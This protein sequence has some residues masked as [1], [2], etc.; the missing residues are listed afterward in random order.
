MII[1]FFLYFC[2]VFLSTFTLNLTLRVKYILVF[3]ILLMLSFFLGFRDHH[4]GTDTI[5]YLVFFKSVPD[6]LS[7]SFLFGGSAPLFQLFMY[8]F[9]SLGLSGESFL[10]FCALFLNM[11]IFRLSVFFKAESPIFVVLLLPSL[12]YFLFSLNIMRQGIAVVSFIL[13]FLCLEKGRLK[14]TTFWCGIA[15]LFHPSV[16][17]PMVIV[18]FLKKIKE[19]R[20]YS[21]FIFFASAFLLIFSVDIS[22]FILPF[23]KYFSFFSVLVHRV[24]FYLTA[25]DIK[26]SSIGVGYLCTYIIWIFSAIFNKKMTFLTKSYGFNYKSSEVFSKF[27]GVNVV[28]YPLVSPYAAIARLSF[29]FYIFEVIFFLFFLNVFSNKVRVVLVLFV[30]TFLYFKSVYSGFLY[31][32]L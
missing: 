13:A 14:E 21:F 31:G 3:I 8:S 4:V 2:L 18:F 28:L 15:L 27:L 12:T 20:V 29:Y 7:Y 9:S 5:N 11:L 30:S 17:F 22:V 25:Y 26:G 10:F 32:F 6:E 16:L 23:L 24:E 1:Y 19:F